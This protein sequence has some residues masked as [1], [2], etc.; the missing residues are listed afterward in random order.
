MLEQIME[1]LTG[2]EMIAL[3]S[4]MAGNVILSIV[5][6]LVKKVFTFRKIGD[7]VGTKV[8]PLVVYIIVALFA[9]FSP[10]WAPLAVTA[11][12]GL[13]AMYTAGILAAAKSLGLPLPNIFTEKEK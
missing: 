5:A 8:G 6:A 10:D 13:I 1:V 12:A 9:E 7:F 2:S 3:T 11:M 4:L